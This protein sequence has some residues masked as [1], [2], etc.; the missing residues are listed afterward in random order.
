MNTNYPIHPKEKVARANEESMLNWLRENDDKLPITIYGLSKSMKWS[1]GATRGTLLRLHAQPESKIH[2]E[3]IFDPQ[4][5][6]FKT[7][8]AIKGAPSFDRLEEIKVDISQKTNDVSGKQNSP[9]K[10]LDFS[11]VYYFLTK[12]DEMDRNV[13]KIAT[14]IS[15]VNLLQKFLDLNFGLKLEEKEQLLEILAIMEENFNVIG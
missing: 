13:S 7:L 1:F 14:E 15:D 9:A 11:K 4:K 3:G 8:I 6:K 2:L 12:L 10:I 5:K